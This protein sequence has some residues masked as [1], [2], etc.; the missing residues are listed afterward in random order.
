MT[1]YVIVQ[2]LYCDDKAA[3]R[4]AL[5]EACFAAHAAPQVDEEIPSPKDNYPQ[6][7]LHDV[8]GIPPHT[9]RLAAFILDFLLLSLVADLVSIV[10]VGLFA[11][12]TDLIAQRGAA[13]SNDNPA[14]L[15][16]HIAELRIFAVIMIG[17][18]LI[19]AALYHLFF[20]SFYGA[21]PG[22]MICGLTLASTA[23]NSLTAD[24]VLK[25][26]AIKG[27]AYA[28]YIL[29]IPGQAVGWGQMGWFS[30]V[31]AFLGVMI[32]IINLINPLLVFYK[33][34]RGLHDMVA[35]TRVVVDK[36]ASVARY[37]TWLIVV[38]LTIAAR[39]MLLG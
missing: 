4:K 27:S 24:A 7:E 12:D 23:D 14:L 29:L 5:C 9:P 22:K 32:S 34:R 36:E 21:T 11:V 18:N 26:F 13:T 35:G 16:Q 8:I 37:A 31:L 19:P 39:K 6:T 1:E 10:A 38:A 20:E 25:R 15:S 3:P 30:L 28:Y 33:E 17:A 2:C